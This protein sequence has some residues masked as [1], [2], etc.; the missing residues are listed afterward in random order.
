MGMVRGDKMR[1]AA[2][3]LRSKDKGLPG[4][5]HYGLLGHGD[6]G[7]ALQEVEKVILQRQRAW[8]HGLS[9]PPLSDSKGRAN[10]GTRKCPSA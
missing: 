8:A 3:P 7:E 10:H 2:A 9:E 4:G 5:E 6:A 1:L